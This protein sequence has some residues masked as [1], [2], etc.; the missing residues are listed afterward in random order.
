MIPF[1]TKYQFLLS[2][3]TFQVLLKVFQDLRTPF[4]TNYFFILT[5]DQ[6]FSSYSQW[7]QFLLFTFSNHKQAKYQNSWHLLALNASFYFLLLRLKHCLTFFK[8][9]DS[10][11]YFLLLHFNNRPKFFKLRS[12]YPV[13]TFYIL[14]P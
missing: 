4:F 9:L 2:T 10:S 13:F 11:F 6:N 7:I 5:L 1:S 8:F 3:S 14:K 12:V